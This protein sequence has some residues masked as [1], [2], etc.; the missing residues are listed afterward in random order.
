[1]NSAENPSATTPLDF[2]KIPA[3]TEFGHRAE[4]FGSVAEV[5]DHQIRRDLHPGA[6]LVVLRHGKIAVDRHGGYVGSDKRVKL[7]PH[8]RFLTFSLA[9][10][11]ATA[12]ILKLQ[13]QGL[14][15]I[16]NP[17]AR[18]WPEF[19][20]MGKDKITIRQVLLHQ[21]G[22][23]NTGMLG[24]MRHITSWQKIVG[25]IASQKPAFDPG[26]KSQYQVLN[27]GFILG[28][29]VSRTTGIPI[30]QYLDEQFL[31]PMGVV[32]TSMRYRSEDEH[33][34]A[35]H[36]YRTLANRVVGWAFDSEGARNALIPSASLYSTARDLAV[37]LQMF[38]NN[39]R[40]GGVQYLRDETASS[41]TS[42][43]FEGHDHSLERIVRFGLGFFLGEEVAMGKG[44]SVE[45]F[46]HYGQRSSMVWA[47][48]RTQT[49]VA[50][51]C[52]RP[53]SSLAYKARLRELSDAVW[54][55][56]DR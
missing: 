45:T 36:S 22:L 8:T 38:L 55:V 18:Y 5:F 12:C 29:L 24:Q 39:G 47:D 9:K 10:V 2:D 41:A 3:N 21:S 33:L 27:V 53:L 51:G 32:D 20:A 16:G 46:G 56:V 35:E 37:F 26:S 30:D 48:R 1:M 49:V 14:V 15:D 19:A 4:G 23:P 28:E 34:Y 13:D 11:A 40:Y 6:Q 25:D 52:N 17:V 7:T 43:S 54:D 44:S 42:L 31:A 50:F